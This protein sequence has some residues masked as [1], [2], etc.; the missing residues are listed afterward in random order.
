M[1]N[2]STRKYAFTKSL[3]KIV[4]RENFSKKAEIIKHSQDSTQEAATFFVQC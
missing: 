1:V 4:D 3:I 2:T